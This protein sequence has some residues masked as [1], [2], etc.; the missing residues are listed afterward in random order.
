[1]DCL[2]IVKVHND[3]QLIV[4]QLLGRD[5]SDHHLLAPPVA[6]LISSVI[7]GVTSLATE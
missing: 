1:M 7:S 5:S 4:E 6:Q 3:P 2:S